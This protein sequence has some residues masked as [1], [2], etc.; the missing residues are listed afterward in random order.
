MNSRSLRLVPATLLLLTAAASARLG[1]S[2]AQSQTRYGAPAPELSGPQEAPLLPGAK[3][4]IY[5][6]EGWRV[7]VAFL[8][9]RAARLEYAKIPD[10][11]GLKKLTDDEVQAVLAAEKGTLTWREE[12]PRTGVDGLNK[13]KLALDG[14]TWERSDHAM[15]RFKGG[16]MLVLDSRD[17]E[18]WEKKQAKGG[19]A[20][21]AP[22]G[23]PKF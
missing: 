7:R 10:A 18:A 19:K 12:K 6:N 1:E 17:V 16:M 4:V 15:A 21:P 3:E 22:T 9:D 5:K 11:A 14:R 13:L 8:S 20:T 2:E 23:L